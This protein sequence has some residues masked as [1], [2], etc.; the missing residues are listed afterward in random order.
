[1]PSVCGLHRL[2]Y[3]QNIAY[4]SNPLKNVSYELACKIPTILPLSVKNS[5]SWSWRISSRSRLYANAT[6]Q[7]CQYWAFKL[8]SLTFASYH[9]YILWQPRLAVQRYWGNLFLDHFLANRF[10]HSRWLVRLWLETRLWP[11]NV[12]SSI[13]GRVASDATGNFVVLGVLALQCHCCASI[14]LF[15]EGTMDALTRL[16][17]VLQN[18][19]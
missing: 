3:W 18:T 10:Q 12:Y 5:G 1:M 9:N 19:S 14:Y 17:L 11:I 16:Y 4:I 2:F 7:A 13:Y 15:T 8:S 6:L